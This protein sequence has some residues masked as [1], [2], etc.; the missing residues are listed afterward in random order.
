M[1]L[2][3]KDQA[4]RLAN[5][6]LENPSVD[7]DSDLAV[8]SRQFLR[9]LKYSDRIPKPFYEDGPAIEHQ[10]IAVIKSITPMQI[11]NE[12]KE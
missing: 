1:S 3:E 6:I 9:A 11:I 2:S 5:A 12:E 8:L 7:P 10:E 4:V